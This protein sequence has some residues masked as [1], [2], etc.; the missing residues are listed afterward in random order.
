MND[1]FQHDEHP[2]IS[3][4]ASKG[5][6]LHSTLDFDLQQLRQRSYTIIAQEPFI[7][8][9]FSEFIQQLLNP[10]CL[11]FEAVKLREYIHKCWEDY[12]NR[13][14]LNS[15]CE[16]DKSS[17]AHSSNNYQTFVGALSHYIYDKY[18]QYRR[19]RPSAE[20]SYNTDQIYV[21]SF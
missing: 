1:T 15:S 20:S 9:E 16:P 2:A 4:T 11:N 13:I 6:D 21:S 3:R 17:D 12:E 7:D 18:G 14:N 5:Q 10:S 8:A 19:Q